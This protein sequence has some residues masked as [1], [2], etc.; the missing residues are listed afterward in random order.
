MERTLRVPRA[1][2]HRML[3][4]LREALPLEACGIMAGRDGA[5]TFLYPI[6]NLLQ[7]PTEYYMDPSQQL[8]AML[9]LE[10]EGWEMLAIYHSHPEGPAYPSQTDIT[11]AFYPE[12]VHLIVSFA[13]RE[14]PSARAFAI[15]DG[16]V[17]EL[18]LK[19]V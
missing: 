4:H 14:R 19:I 11:R 6:D 7:S 12:S 5:V 13:H 1:E 8:Q 10:K 15:A 17:E 2:F 16:V 18:N 9:A 3:T